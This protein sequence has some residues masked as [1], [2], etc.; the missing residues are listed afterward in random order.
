V[1]FTPTTLG[2]AA[3]S[4]D[5]PSNDP[6]P[7]TANN[8]N[9]VLVVLTG[10]GTA[11]APPGPPP[12]PSPPP[13]GP[14]PPPGGGPAP[15]PSPTPPGGPTP[16]PSLSNPP[17]WPFTVPAA[18]GEALVADDSGVVVAGYA[19]NGGTFDLLLARFA[20]DGTKQWERRLDLGG[21]EFGYGLAQDSLGR[22]TVVGYSQIGV[23]AGML[24]AQYD[25]NGS[26]LW[27]KVIPGDFAAGYAVVAG[28]DDSLYVTGERWNGI[29]TDLWLLK[30]SSAGD[31]Q[32]N[33]VRNE[34]GDEIGYGLALT[35]TGLYAVGSKNTTLWGC[36]FTL[37]GAVQGC[38]TGGPGIAYQVAVEPASNDLYLGG[39]LAACRT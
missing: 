26:L 19:S 29:N 32:W 20:T 6:D 27:Q 35:A 18:S 17:L 21:H 3:G 5:V 30:L 15:P 13:P 4:F 28:P 9:N 16:P 10:T 36:L 2:A 11:A 12:P 31:V 25:A 7:G 8:Q 39:L 22:L 38:A 23:L 24:V 37:G 34:G 1:R 33:T 14:T